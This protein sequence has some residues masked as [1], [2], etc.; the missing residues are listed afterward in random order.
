M[1]LHEQL[2]HVKLKKVKDITS[3]PEGREFSE[4]YSLYKQEQKVN[5]LYKQTELVDLLK[6]TSQYQVLLPGQR[7]L[8][9]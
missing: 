8:L 6:L 1:L 9:N 3:S 7:D 4:K 5:P 2:G